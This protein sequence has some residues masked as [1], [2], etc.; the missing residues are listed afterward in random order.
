[1]RSSLPRMQSHLRTIL[2]AFGPE[3]ARQPPLHYPPTPKDDRIAY[4][5]LVVRLAATRYNVPLDRVHV[6][7]TNEQF[8]RE[9]GR[10]RQTGRGTFIDVMSQYRDHDAMLTVIVA[11]EM[12]HYALANR[13]IWIDD[14]QENEELTDTLA[15]LVGFG[16]LMIDAYHREFSGVQGQ[17][18]YTSIFGLG[19]LHPT[20][21]AY[22]TLVQ[23]V[24][25]GLDP[26]GQID[27]RS[28][29]FH[30]PMSTLQSARATRSNGDSY[31]YLCGHDMPNPGSGTRQL[32]SCKLCRVI[33]RVET[34][35]SRP[36]A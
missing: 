19:Y 18:L 35:V 15:V 6:R 17:T 29:W 23:C 14:K 33:Q 13:R 12:A 8:D 16:P 10:I 9:A 7:F 24:L 32:V 31:C 11:H 4:L 27:V 30:E 28:P 5:K 34:V 20:A 22:F 1:M 36:V 2:A 3:I 26:R 21:V 25:A